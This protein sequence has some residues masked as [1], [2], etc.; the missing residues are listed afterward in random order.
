MKF[1]FEVYRQTRK[2]I[3]FFLDDLNEDK[4]NCIPDG[5]KNNIVWNLGHILVTQQLLFYGNSGN[6]LK[7]PGEW[8]DKYRKGTKPE[9]RVSMEEFDK[10]KAMLVSTIDESERDY[11][12]G[13]FSSYN[14]YATSYGVQINSI[15]DLI[16]F[17]YAHD[18][19][20]WGI[21]VAMKKLV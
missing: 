10:M 9:G 13:L 16:R 8:V 4:I 11:V 14:A 3:L 19:F 18:G 20:H 7:I 17:I 5:F 2:N 21:I 1:P 12:S 6:E 15:E